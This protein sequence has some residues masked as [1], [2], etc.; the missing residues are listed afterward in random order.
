MHMYKCEKHING[1]R[2]QYWLYASLN[3]RFGTEVKFQRDSLH[4]RYAVNR[5]GFSVKTN[6]QSLSD[7][8]AF[9]VRH[10]LAAGFTSAPDDRSG[11]TKVTQRETGVERLYVSVEE[12][13]ALKEI[14]V[15]GFVN[16]TRLP[17]FKSRVEH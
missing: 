5:H 11:Y 15:M 10:L 3:K 12:V 13:P 9:L 1:Y 14:R 17:Q 7:V 2:L 16:W 6:T 4:S 8:K